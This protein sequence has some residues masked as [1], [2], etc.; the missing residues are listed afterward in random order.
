MSLTQIRRSNF[1]DLFSMFKFETLYSYNQ[2]FFEPYDMTGDKPLLLKVPG[3]S[4]KDIKVKVNGRSL[5]ISGE[6]PETVDLT[7]SRSFSHTYTYSR[8]LDSSKVK[9]Q[10][11]DGLLTVEVGFVDDS[12]SKEGI[13]IEVK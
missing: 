1:G 13:E 2:S 10:C 11:K 6:L 8:Q 12:G 5:Y 7:G 3:Y 9:A 4:S